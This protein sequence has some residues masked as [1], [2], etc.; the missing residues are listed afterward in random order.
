MRELLSPGGGHMNIM[1]ITCSQIHN[2]RTELVW[3]AEQQ[4][5]LSR[6]LHEFI[7]AHLSN[8]PEAKLHRIIPIRAYASEINL[9]GE[10]SPRDALLKVANVF[11]LEIC[12]EYPEVRGS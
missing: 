5:F 8:F 11:G 9:C 4:K 3:L 12:D 7:I 10:V 1:R 6:E 2:L